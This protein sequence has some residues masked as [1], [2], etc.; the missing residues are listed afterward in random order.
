VTW[1]TD[2]NGDRLARAILCLA[3]AIWSVGMFWFSLISGVQHDYK[4]YLFQW[5]LALSGADPWSKD[6]ANA[7][8][9]LHNLLAYATTFGPLGPKVIIVICLIAANALLV[10]ELL[11]TKAINGNYVVYLLAVPTNILI[12]S[13]AFAYG[14][15]DALVAA[16]IA[17]SV[18]ARSRGRTSLAGC[19]LGLAIL[20]KYYAVFLIPL[21][22][23]EKGRFSWRLIAGA[24]IVTAAGL[25]ANL[26]VWGDT[27]LA[28]LFFGVE[29]E[30]KILSILAALNDHPFLI[31]PDILTFLIRTNVIFVL[32][33]EMLIIFVSWYLRL[34]WLEAS[35]LGLL[36]V[37]LTY[38]VGHQQ[39]F[40]PWLFLVSALPLA[41][42]DS[43]RRLAWFCA[44][45]VLFLSAFQWG[46]E[47]GSDHYRKV[48][49][50]IRDD[51]GF[52]AFPSGVAIILTYFFTR[53]G[54]AN[55]VSPVAQLRPRRGAKHCCEY[56][57]AAGAGAKP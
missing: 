4:V 15:N 38:K 26:L 6:S 5:A 34:H 2:Q 48:H 23:L 53:G 16:F 18:V 10:A 11:R 57:Q 32:A 40:I 52:V 28:A 51:V 8:G 43:A 1:P 56:R 19:I 27:F 35:V 25:A 47:Y 20:L 30:P 31:S 45:F 33:V 3:L 41:Q 50:E 17:C 42:T 7:Y 46:Y 37:L 36:A 24:A 13:M 14:L 39:F 29:R 9:P 22:A 21:F 49:G 44:P 55:S 54:R 12:I